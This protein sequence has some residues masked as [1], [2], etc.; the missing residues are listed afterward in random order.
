MNTGSK[1][2]PKQQGFTLIEIM[3]VIVILGI[4]GTIVAPKVLKSPDKARVT[5]AKQDLQVISAA[6]DMYKLDNFN[7]PDTDQ[8][9]EALVERPASGEDVPNWQEGGY[10]KKV[11]TDPWGR[12]YLYMSP[13]ENDEVD[14]YSLGSDGAPGGDGAASDIGSWE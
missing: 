12:D 3:V 1:R 4:L 10:V 11:P 9:L 14:I 5:K 7:Y 13:G 6:L 8:G 2:H